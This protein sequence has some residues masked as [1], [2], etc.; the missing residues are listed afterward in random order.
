MLYYVQREFNIDLKYM[1]NNLMYEAYKQALLSFSIGEVPVGCVI[2]RHNSKIRDITVAKNMTITLS[3]P[4]AH[5]E[6]LAIRDLYKRIS[7]KNLKEYDLYTTLEP[8]PMCAQL[9]SISKIRRLY[10]GAYDIKGGG[11]ENGAK[12]F[13]QSSCFHKPEIYGGI[14][15]EKC[16]H[17]MI[18]FFKELRAKKL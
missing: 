6:I 18:K 2:V 17:L 10:F 11:V 3:D 7:S 8:C 13:N 1:Y 4:S 16:S 9:I 12:I 5:A 14:M 15:E